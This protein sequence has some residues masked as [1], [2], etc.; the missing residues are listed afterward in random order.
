MYYLCVHE[1]KEDRIIGTGSDSHG[2]GNFVRIVLPSLGTAYFL[3]FNA[4][5]SNFLD[6]VVPLIILGLIAPGIAELG[7]GQGKCWEQQ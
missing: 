2:A 1:E 5:F 3:T 6:F 7:R 4:L